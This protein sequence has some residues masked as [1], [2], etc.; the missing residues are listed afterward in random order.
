MT[1]EVRQFMGETIHPDFIEKDQSVYVL[2]EDHL[3][4][5]KEQ[6]SKVREAWIKFFNNFKWIYGKH[7]KN[8]YTLCQFRRKMTEYNND[9]KKELGL[10]SEENP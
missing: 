3:K 10:T 8:E 5:M 6:K 9:L 1:F 2:L 4:A 7:L